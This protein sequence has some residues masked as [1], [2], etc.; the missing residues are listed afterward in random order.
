MV[1]VKVNISLME[2][3]DLFGDDGSHTVSVI[4][5]GFLI[6]FKNF[7]STNRTIVCDYQL[8]VVSNLL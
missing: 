2:E 7:F 6:E 4:I 8:R 3:N 5:A 1:T